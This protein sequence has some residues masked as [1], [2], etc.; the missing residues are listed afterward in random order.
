MRQA[1]W[2]VRRG[3]FHVGA[4]IRRGRQRLDP[5]AAEHQRKRAERSGPAAAALCVAQVSVKLEFQFFAG[6]E[7]GLDLPQRD[8]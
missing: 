7:I 1:F 4:G 6:V 5:Q 8:A 3:T 2:W